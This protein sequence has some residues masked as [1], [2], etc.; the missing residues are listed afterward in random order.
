[1][2]IFTLWEVEE[3]EEEIANLECNWLDG[4]SNYSERRLFV[5]E[6]VL[7]LRED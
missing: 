7:T 4:H 3:D 1:M 2:N 5:E 6:Y